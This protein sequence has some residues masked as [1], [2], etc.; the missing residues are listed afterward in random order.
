MTASPSTSDSIDDKKACSENDKT[1]EPLRLLVLG[2]VSSGKSSLINALFGDTK[3]AVSILPTTSEITPY[4]L[5]RDGLQQA[6][7]L[8]SAD[9]GSLTYHTDAMKKAWTK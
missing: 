2:Q 7:I 4:I 1:P 5:E 3:S 6:I 9:Y 8:D